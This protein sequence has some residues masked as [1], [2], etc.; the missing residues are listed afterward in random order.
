VISTLARSKQATSQPRTVNSEQSS[1]P[2]CPALPKTAT[3]FTSLLSASVARK[4]QL[5]G[6]YLC[7]SLQPRTKF[8]DPPAFWRLDSEQVAVPRPELRETCQTVPDVGADSKSTFLRLAI[9][10]FTEQQE[11]FGFHLNGGIHSNRP[12]HPETDALL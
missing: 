12:R 11:I 6:W 10:N 9:T 5:A 4:P 2:N 3:R 8:W 1:I 7:F